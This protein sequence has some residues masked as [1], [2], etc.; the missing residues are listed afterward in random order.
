MTKTLLIAG[1][2]TCALMAWRL[3]PLTPSPVA[4]EAASA[5]TFSVEDYEDMRPADHDDPDSML[6]LLF[7]VGTEGELHLNKFWCLAGTA[8]KSRELP[9]WGRFYTWRVIAQD[10]EVLVRGTH[11][12][13]LARYTPSQEGGCD[14]TIAGEHAMLVRVPDHDRAHTVEIEIDRVRTDMEEN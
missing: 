1:V 7:D 14:K 10:G 11:F 3:T 6:A 9:D 4:A 2:M 8:P 12:D 5:W 13:H